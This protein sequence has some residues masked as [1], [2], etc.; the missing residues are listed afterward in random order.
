MT[1]TDKAMIFKFIHFSEEGTFKSLNDPQTSTV[2]IWS[3]KVPQDFS[4]GRNNLKLVNQWVKI[5]SN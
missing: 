4:W 1:K 2:S 3:A 5:G